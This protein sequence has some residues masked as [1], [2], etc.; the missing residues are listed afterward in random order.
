M[1]KFC[2]IRKTNTSKEGENVFTK[3]DE[4]SGDKVVILKSIQKK[5]VATTISEITSVR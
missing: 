4:R 2:Y 3:K 5:F 1:Q